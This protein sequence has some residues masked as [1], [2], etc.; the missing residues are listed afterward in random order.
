MEFAWFEFTEFELAAF[1]L[2]GFELT[3]F[4]LAAFELAAFKLP[5]KFEIPIIWTSQFRANKTE[6]KSSDEKN[7]NFL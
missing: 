3:G 4:E 6:R 5:H 1:E 2:T 7:P